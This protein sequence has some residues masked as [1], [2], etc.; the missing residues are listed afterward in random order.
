MGLSVT[1][2]MRDTTATPNWRPFAA[3]QN[4]LLHYT[5]FTLSSAVDALRINQQFLNFLVGCRVILQYTQHLLQLW[6]SHFIVDFLSISASIVHVAVGCIE[7]QEHTAL[8]VVHDG[9]DL[10]FGGQNNKPHQLL[11]VLTEEW[12]TYF[13]VD[14]GCTHTF[15]EVDDALLELLGV[16]EVI[17]RAV[18]QVHHTLESQINDIEN[19]LSM[20]RCLFAFRYHEI[21]HR[22][23]YLALYHP[24]DVL[25]HESKANC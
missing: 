2:C 10:P 7:H 3:T 9:V 8:Q 4:D 25:A 15:V 22:Q 1:T 24:I 20:F 13:D 12:A 14:D 23:E 5:S 17:A 11:E 6:S 21:S 19:F 16:L 18:L